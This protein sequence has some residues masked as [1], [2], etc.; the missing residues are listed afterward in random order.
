MF[1][2]SPEKCDRLVLPLSLSA[3]SGRLRESLGISGLGHVV[4]IPAS[5]AIICMPKRIQFDVECWREDAL[6]MVSV[7]SS[8]FVLSF[9]FFNHF[10]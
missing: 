9:F 3:S 10:E 5:A 4:S 7:Y 8:F 6:T 1:S 2:D